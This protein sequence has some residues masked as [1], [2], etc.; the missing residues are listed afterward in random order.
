MPVGGLPVRPTGPVPVPH[1]GPAVGRHPRL[2]LRQV[3]HHLRRQR[4]LDDGRGVRLLDQPRHRHR[5]PRRARPRPAHRDPPGDRGRP[6]R[7]RRSLPPHPGLLRPR[8]HRGAPGR[9]PGERTAAPTIRRSP[10][11]ATWRRPRSP[12]PRSSAPACW[13]WARRP[14]RAGHG[15]GRRPA[16]RVSPS[17]PILWWPRLGPAIPTG[18]GPA[19]RSVGRLWWLAS[20]GVVAALLAAWWVL[21][22]FAQRTY[23]NDMG[24]GKIAVHA[25]GIG[26]LVLVHRLGV[27]RARAGRSQGGG[28]PRA[29]RR[30]ALVGLQAPH[31]DRRW[32]CSASCSPPRSSSCPRAGCG[33][34]A[35]SRSGTSS[36]TSWPPSAWARSSGP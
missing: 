16:V 27:A 30:R 35:C 10:G 9:A 17:S 12:S 34:P 11:A 33:T 31:R 6:A 29:R 28:R 32:S 20:T 5:L 8:G 23:L 7:P 3:V 26:P 22:F 15:R 25:E 1:A 18:P 19:A 21:P 4:G 2:P 14:R 13:R 24:W 36:S